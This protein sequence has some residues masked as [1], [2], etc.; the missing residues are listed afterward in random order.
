MFADIDPNGGV[1]H[2]P[3]IF[4]P[5]KDSDRLAIPAWPPT[6][7][8]SPGINFTQ[9]NEP[10]PGIYCGK[11]QQQQWL[12]PF[13]HVSLKYSNYF[14]YPIYI[15]ADG[16]SD[17]NPSAVDESL[18]IAR[19]KEGPKI[20]TQSHRLNFGRFVKAKHLISKFSNLETK[21]IM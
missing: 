15:K 3:T 14:P 2:T 13:L 11:Q 6:A 4:S 18:E 16:D 9:S 12:A 7:V 17:D 8:W 10:H 21:L 5:R 20:Q 19:P 1:Y